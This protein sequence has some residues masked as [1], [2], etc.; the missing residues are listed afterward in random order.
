MFAVLHAVLALYLAKIL[1]FGV[2]LEYNDSLCELVGEG[3]LS[4]GS[5]DLVIL[6]QGVVLV[7]S[8][9]LDSVLFGRHGTTTPGSIVKLN[10][11]TREALP[12]TISGYPD[13][14]PFQPHGIFLSNSTRRL[15]AVTHGIGIP[16]RIAVFHLISEESDDRLS[17][18]KFIESPKFGRSRINDVVEGDLGEVFVTVWLANDV[19]L[20]GKNRERGLDMLWSQ[21]ELLGIF[22]PRTEVLRC[23]DNNC[24]TAAEGF[25]MANGITISDDRSRVFVVDVHLHTV[26]EFWRSDSGVLTFVQEIPTGDM[27]ID[28]IEWVEGRLMMGSGGPLNRAISRTHGDSSV[29]V[30]GGMRV[31]EE[32]DGEWVGSQVLTHD[33]AKLSMISAGLE[34]LNNV[35]LGSPCSSGVLVCPLI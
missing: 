33:G 18:E 9:D 8:G 20:D 32:I 10:L 7:S 19:A 35:V 6:R 27:Y 23:I 12:L 5:E 30:P 24:E 1:Q 21:I 34:T 25:Y 14:I 11:V 31:Y 3:V 17:F 2:N 15:Y 4:Q 22:Y 26:V 13:S 29:L 16:S 28:N